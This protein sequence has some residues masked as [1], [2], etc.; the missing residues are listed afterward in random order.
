MKKL[1]GIV[2]VLLIAPVLIIGLQ[3]CDDCSNNGSNNPIYYKLISGYIANFYKSD[4]LW[5]R[6]KTFVEGDTV[7]H[8]LLKNIEF[9]FA[10]E[11]VAMLQKSPSNG[12]YLYACSLPPII[13]YPTQNINRISLIS[14]YPL[15]DSISSNDTI[16]RLVQAITYPRYN[17]FNKVV[18]NLEDL[19]G[20]SAYNS[21]RISFKNIP[22]PDTT[23]PFQVEMILELSDNTTIRAMSSKV[24]LG[25]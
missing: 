6:V 8:D 23:S 3:S 20:T 17:G 13:S 25:N 11:R 18:S 12:S 19:I 2:L 14:K 16:N 21:L 9:Y 15:G 22:V 1:L 4:S 5:S 7:P 10:T 24:Y